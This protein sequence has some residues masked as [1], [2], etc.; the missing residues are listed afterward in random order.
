MQ[1]HPPSPGGGGG[2]GRALAV[3]RMGNVPR[4]QR[5]VQVGTRAGEAG[6]TGSV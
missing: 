2:G 6:A 4:D 5:Q 1:R 3:H